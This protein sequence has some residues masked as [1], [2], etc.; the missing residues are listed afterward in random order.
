MFGGSAPT[1]EENT[2]CLASV[3]TFLDKLEKRFSANGGRKYCAGDQITAADFHLVALETRL[4]SNPNSKVPETA[5][6]AKAEVEKRP[7]VKAIIDRV[8]GENGL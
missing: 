8:K 6:K 4:F 3:N 2:K 7:T 1:E 5:A